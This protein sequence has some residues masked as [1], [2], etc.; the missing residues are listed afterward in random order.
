MIRVKLFVCPHQSDEVFGFRQIDDVVRDEK[1]AFG[2]VP[3]LS[4]GNTGFGDIDRELAA[5]EGL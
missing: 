4:F 3:M 5:I 2:V 1:F